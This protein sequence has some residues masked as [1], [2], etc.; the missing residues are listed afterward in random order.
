MAHELQERELEVNLARIFD[1]PTEL[2][3]K[4][5][6]YGKY[7]DALTLAP[8]K[9]PD[10]KEQLRTAMRHKVMAERV[11]RNRRAKLLTQVATDT[12]LRALL[13]LP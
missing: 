9:G 4:S 5:Y 7:A 8:F 2:D 11:D 1:F 10:V 12:S 6:A 13:D 3:S